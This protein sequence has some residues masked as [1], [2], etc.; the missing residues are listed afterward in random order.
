M[1]GRRSRRTFK[2]PFAKCPRPN[3]A[4]QPTG[5]SLWLLPHTWPTQQRHLQPNTLHH[6]LALCAA[7]AAFELARLLSVAAHTDEVAW[8]VA[9]G[10]ALLLLLVGLVLYRNWRY[11]QQL[12]SLLWKLDYR[13]I[14]QL[15][16]NRTCRRRFRHADVNDSAQ[17]VRTSQV[18]LSSN[19]GELEFRYGQL[20]AAVGIYRGRALAVKK[21]RKRSIDITRAMKKEL[22]LM[23]DLRHDNINAFVGACTEPPNICIVT[24]YCSRGSL[25]DILENEDVKLDNMFIASL[26]GDIIR[27]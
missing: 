8:G 3:R 20:Y 17:A 14:Q 11:E 5:H 16:V 13:D 4:I 27:V 23:R 22:K 19:P 26:V 21:V 24:E 10:A 18:S 6:T 2:F 12:D 25:K 15:E 1:Q 9:G 7:A